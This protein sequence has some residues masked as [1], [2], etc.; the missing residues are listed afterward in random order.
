MN[1]EELPVF[2][3]AEAAAT[4][5]T[6]AALAGEHPWDAVTLLV[7]RLVAAQEQGENPA[8]EQSRKKERNKE[9][10]KEEDGYALDVGWLERVDAVGEGGARARMWAAS[11]SAVELGRVD[12]RMGR[13]SRRAMGHE[14]KGR[15]YGSWRTHLFSPM[16]SPITDRRRVLDWLE[17]TADA[18]SAP[19]QPYH[20]HR[21][22]LGGGAYITRYTAA[23]VW[24]LRRRGPLPLDT[25]HTSNGSSV[26]IIR[27][28]AVRPELLLEGHVHEWDEDANHNHKRA[29][30]PALNKAI[31]GLQEVRAGEAVAAECAVCLQDFV[32]EDKLRAMPCSHAFH[33]KCIFDWLRVNHVCPLC[34]H[35]LSTQDDDEFWKHPSMP[36]DDDDED[37]MHSSMLFLDAE[38]VF[39]RRSQIRIE[40]SP[41]RPSAQLTVMIPSSSPIPMNILLAVIGWLPDPEGATIFADDTVGEGESGVGAAGKAAEGNSRVAG[42]GS[43]GAAVEGANGG[44]GTTGEGEEGGGGPEGEGGHAVASTLTAPMSSP[45]TGRRRVLDW[46]EETDAGSAPLQ[47]FH[48]HWQDLG[49]GAY[50]TRYTGTVIR[51]LALESSEPLPLDTFHTSTGS[52]VRIIPDWAIWPE[53]LSD[54]RVHE[55]EEEDDANHNHKRARVPASNKAILILQ[56]VSAGEAVAEECAVCLQDFVADDKLRAMPCSH[57]FHHK[58]IFDWLRINHVCPL[59]CHALPTQDDDDDDEFW[60]HPSMPVHDEA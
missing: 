11:S 29:R 14:R 56:E 27:D 46:L 54:D 18:G 43:V 47:P 50:I 3:A 45:I 58:F 42:K 38:I 7:P 15:I 12:A 49:G 39:I 52:S 6:P 48:S 31:L 1:A 8:L 55:R 17:E 35:A 10:V 25:I 23:V 2:I 57:A 51:R 24:T 41:L 32:A 16:S 34:R 19:P 26:R 21:E 4:A 13:C 20:S 22:D 53:L 40:L 9:A 44:G 30:V 60:K 33:Q 36:G 28:W 37:W 5:L 59:C